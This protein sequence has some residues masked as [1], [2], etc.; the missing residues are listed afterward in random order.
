[1]RI[2][3]GWLSKYV[4]KVSHGFT[5]LINTVGNLMKMRKNSSYCKTFSKP[6]ISFFGRI[7]GNNRAN[8]HMLNFMMKIEF[9][10]LAI[11]FSH[12]PIPQFFHVSFSSTTFWCYISVGHNSTWRNNKIFSQYKNNGWKTYISHKFFIKPE[13]NYW[14]N[15]PV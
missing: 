6:K 7:D 15:F 9:S 4:P 12:I 11:I 13:K 1:M 2:S 3:S 10:N 14:N 8:R 5:S